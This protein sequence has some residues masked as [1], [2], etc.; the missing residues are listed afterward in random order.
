M[1]HFTSTGAIELINIMVCWTQTDFS[2]KA[3]T[4]YE[5]IKSDQA[6]LAEMASLVEVRGLYV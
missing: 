6:P 4:S 2:N 1:S 5:L 3:V